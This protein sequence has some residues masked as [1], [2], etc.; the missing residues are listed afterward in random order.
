MINKIFV[1]LDYQ[2]NK[3]DEVKTRALCYCVLIYIYYAEDIRKCIL[4]NFKSVNN[5]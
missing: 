3:N 2:E 5:G 1:L 4:D